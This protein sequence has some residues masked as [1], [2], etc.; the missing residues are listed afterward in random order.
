MEQL[1]DDFKTER[2]NW[3]TEKAAL[4]KRAEEAE[5]ALKLVE[6]ELTGLKHQVNTVTAAVFGTRIAHLGT[7]MQMKLKAAYTLIE[8]FHRGRRA[9]VNGADGHGAAIRQLPDAY[10]TCPAAP[11]TLDRLPSPLSPLSLS[12]FLAPELLSPRSSSSSSSRCPPAS[13]RRSKVS[14]R[15]ASVVHFTCEGKFELKAPARRQRTSSSSP[16]GPVRRRIR[17]V[18]TFPGL[19]DLATDPRHA[20]ALELDATVDDDSYYSGGAYYYVQPAVD[21]E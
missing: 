11:R 14:R 18:P 2:T 16:A 17:C 3:E 8:Q 7:D 4:L 20:G 19:L 15:R 5:A 6:E 12:V 9:S 1:K 13:V 10:K 21:Q